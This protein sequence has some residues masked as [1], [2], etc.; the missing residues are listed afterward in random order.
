MVPFMSPEEIHQEVGEM[1][2]MEELQCGICCHVEILQVVWGPKYHN[3]QV[4]DENDIYRKSSAAVG[5][6]A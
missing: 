6:M 3:K 1:L 4:T 2:R 5:E